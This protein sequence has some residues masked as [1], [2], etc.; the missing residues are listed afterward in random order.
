[1][2]IK[3]FFLFFLGFLVSC[4]DES[5]A[6]SKKELVESV[7]N[8]QAQDIGYRMIEHERKIKDDSSPVGEWI[9]SINYPEI[10]GKID[11]KVKT[12]INNAISIL[13]DKYGCDENGEYTFSSE[14]KYLDIHLLGLNYYALWSCSGG[15]YQSTSEAL[16]FNLD[17]GSIVSLE[18][19]FI[20][21]KK[22]A[23]FYSIVLG[24]IK[25]ELKAGEDCPI[26]DKF[27]Y[28]YKTK[29]S[30]VFVAEME[31][32]VDSG[33]ITEIKYPLAEMKNYLKSDSLLLR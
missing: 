5:N 1:M 24:E 27:D 6:N 25:K 12:K 2:L 21:D 16:V 9:V 23:S 20:N 13:P 10:H 32:H 3:A 29:E 31:F 4:S 11:G 33:C 22:R 18:S 7:K 30:L 15:P 17:T 26:K 28:F 19:E 14:V 8:E